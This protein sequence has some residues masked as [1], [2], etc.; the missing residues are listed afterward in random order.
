[1]LVCLYLSRSV[2]LVRALG[3]ENHITS[4]CLNLNVRLE[5]VVSVWCVL[6]R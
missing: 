1:M 6:L 2:L 5:G 3:F 4:S